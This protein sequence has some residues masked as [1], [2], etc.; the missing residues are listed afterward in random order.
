LQRSGLVFTHLNAAT[1]PDY[2]MTSADPNW[3]KP[4]GVEQRNAGLAWLRDAFDKGQLD[5]GVV[6]FADDDNTYDTR[7]FEE[8]SLDFTCL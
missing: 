7:L 5:A 1:P 6:Y 4:R 3:L 2:K 8:V